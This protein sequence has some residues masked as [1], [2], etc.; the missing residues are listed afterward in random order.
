MSRI[1]STSSS[2]S[3]SSSTSISSSSASSIGSERMRSTQAIAQ[4]LL[5]TPREC[6]QLDLYKNLM[7]Y[8]K[9]SSKFSNE[10]YE[11][12]FKAIMTVFA[13][14]YSNFSERTD[15]SPLQQ[16]YIAKTLAQLSQ[17][18][19]FV[20][21]GTESV[22]YLTLKPEESKED[23]KEHPQEVAK[24]EFAI[25]L[26]RENVLDLAVLLKLED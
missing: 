22:S 13:S 7:T 3:S 25:K 14:K 6:L 23:F 2:L 1:S 9:L 8:L 4:D 15:L 10:E 26:Q 20:E 17:Y 11:G 5:F 12:T 21:S 24:V 18:K 16:L 19:P